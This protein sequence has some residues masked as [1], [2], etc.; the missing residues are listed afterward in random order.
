MGQSHI[1]HSLGIIGAE[2]C[3]HP[4]R[5]K[6]CADL[7]RAYRV[8]TDA[9]EFV[10]ALSDLVKLHC[11]KRLDMTGGSDLAALV[12]IRHNRHVRRI[13]LIEKSLFFAVGK[14]VVIAKKLFLSVLF[15]LC[16][17]F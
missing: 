7:A 6:N 1:V 5:K 2:T 12:I 10:A 16:F 9:A 17:C 4:S 3:A 11:G 15:K 8:E 13:Y 14:L